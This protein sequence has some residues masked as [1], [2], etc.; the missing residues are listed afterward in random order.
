VGEKKMSKYFKQ[1]ALFNPEI[2]GLQPIHIYGIGSIGSHLALSL[3]K[4]GYK[5]ITVYDYDTVEL[6]NTPAQ[7]YK[8]SQNGMLKTQALKNTVEEA[9]G[10]TIS[11]E[12][13]KITTSFQ[14]E[15]TIGSIHII[16]FDNIESRQL[17]YD[18]LKNSNCHL[19]DGRI[20]GFQYEIYTIK[21]KNTKYENSL[22]G[23]FKELTCGEKCLYGV[24][25][26]ISSKITGQVI[27]ISKN[28]KNP[29]KVIGH[30][31]DQ[32]QI[33]QEE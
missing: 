19:I 3:A 4:T 30:L 18:K 6:S 31:L 24:N 26:L 2:E 1:E 29:Y 28:R 10:T 25:S 12:N 13:I 32:T 8:P 7:Q 9:T 14:I 5:N 23:E 20:G 17:I 21:G 16:C 27:N 15:N 33:V 11:T 22:E